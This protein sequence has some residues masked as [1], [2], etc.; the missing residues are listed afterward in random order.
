MK[1]Q[2]FAATFSIALIVASIFVLFGL[3]AVQASGDIATGRIS[4]TVWQDSNNNGVRE[5]QELALVG[6]MVYLQRTGEEVV[7]AMVA[8][9]ETDENGDFVFA[10][11]E[12]G[13]YN[14]FAEDG[15]YSLVEVV[16]VN[17]S[18]SIELSVPAKVMKIFLPLTVR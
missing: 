8:V 3:S 12:E 14:V 15:E 5:P 13:Q 9:V 11:L 1:T 2:K 18:A 6:H 16:G 7:G 4:G 17:A 10:N